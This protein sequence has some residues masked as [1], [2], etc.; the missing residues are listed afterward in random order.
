MGDRAHARFNVN[1][2]LVWLEHHLNACF[3]GLFYQETGIVPEIL[4]LA[5]LYD[6]RGEAIEFSIE[7]RNKGI[8]GVMSTGVQIREILKHHIFGPGGQFV[9]FLDPFL[10]KALYS[11]NV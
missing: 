3:S 1:A 5:G 11:G 6:Q 2:P 7:G 8:L 9:F 10:S 4:S